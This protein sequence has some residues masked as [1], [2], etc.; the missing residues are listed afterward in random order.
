TSPIRGGLRFSLKSAFFFL[1][2]IL[3]IVA[4]ETGMVGTRWCVDRYVMWAFAGGAVLIAVAG[5]TLDIRGGRP[6]SVCVITNHRL[7]LASAARG[8]VR[9]VQR[10]EL[11]SLTGIEVESS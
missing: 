7:L 6:R 4:V 3:A 8:K 11:R 10:L 5:V 1:L 2:L 9:W